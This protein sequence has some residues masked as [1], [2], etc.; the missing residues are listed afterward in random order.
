MLSSRE[1]VTLK[2]RSLAS[3]DTSG[4]RIVKLQKGVDK[5]S[6]AIKHGDSSR[7]REPI[8]S[9]SVASKKQKLMNASRKP[10]NKASSTSTSKTSM[11]EGKPSLGEMLFDYMNK[12][13]EPVKSSKDDTTVSEL[14]QTQ[15][16]KPLPKKLSSSPPLDADSKRRLLVSFHHHIDTFFFPYN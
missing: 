7:K 4:K 13:S 3:K 8:L 15:T 5:A 10:L 12:D 11:D 16:A 2:E 1:E 9:G 14:E 6:S